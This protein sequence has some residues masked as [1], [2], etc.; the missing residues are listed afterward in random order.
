MLE[1]P[2]YCGR[3]SAEGLYDLLLRAGWSE[4]MAQ[5]AANERGMDRL[6]MGESV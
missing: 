5:R 3:L 4:D 6:A 2:D 1:D